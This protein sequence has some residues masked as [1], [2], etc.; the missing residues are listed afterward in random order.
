MYG[1]PKLPSNTI[2]TRKWFIR[3][4]GT[5]ANKLSVNPTR[6]AGRESS[7]GVTWG[8]F[9][10]ALCCMIPDDLVKFDTTS[11]K[12]VT[13]GDVNRIMCCI[14]D[15]ESDVIMIDFPTTATVTVNETEESGPITNSIDLG[16]MIVLAY[17]NDGQNSP[18][19]SIIEVGGEGSGN[20]RV[21]LFYDPG[22]STDPATI[23][24]DGNTIVVTPIPTPV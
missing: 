16:V 4:I 8:E 18:T 20:Y 7:I 15:Y 9:K 24:I 13:I 21:T 6:I 1:I 22:E 11:D 14:W 10:K 12:Y 2:L 23:T 3:I 5:I 19:V 17:T